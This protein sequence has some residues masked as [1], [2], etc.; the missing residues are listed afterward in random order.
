MKTDKTSA[1]KEIGGEKN[2]NK[3]LHQVRKVQSRRLLRYAQKSVWSPKDT[4]QPSSSYT[5]PTMPQKRST[6][7][8]ITVTATETD[9][10]ETQD[11]SPAE[12]KEQQTDTTITATETQSTEEEDTPGTNTPLPSTPVQCSTSYGTRPT[13]PEDKLQTPIR[14]TVS[15]EVTPKKEIAIPEKVN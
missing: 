2:T 12:G 9:S 3:P 14:A 8:D 4:D 5:L 1:A 6:Y 15:A 10:H 13:Q 7:G 11:E